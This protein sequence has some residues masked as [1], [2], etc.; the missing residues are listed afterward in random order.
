MLKSKGQ[1]AIWVILGVV[2]IASFIIFFA[3]DRLPEIIKPSEKAGVFDLQSL[4]DQCTSKTVL[5]A[6]DIMLP[7]GGF[8]QPKNTIKY[9]GKNIEYLCYTSEYYE[10]CTQQ[11]P[12]PLKEMKDEIKNYILQPINRCFSEI[13][14]EVQRRGGRINYKSN[15]DVFVD[16]GPNTINIKIKRDATIEQLGE[17]RKFDEF[18]VDVKSPAYNLAE[19]ANEI[20]K[21][22]GNP[23]RCY[24]EPVGYSLLYNRFNITV[25]NQFQD[26]TKVYTIQD[27]DSKEFMR[28]ATRSCVSKAGL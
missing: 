3:I 16:W 11:H 24:F 17:K 7:Q 27:K 15:Y 28:V 23:K 6:V 19:V 21:Q 9:Y 14:T 2:L 18:N 22:E 12:V 1:I 20:A 8:L 4:L 26:G 5:E 13:D 25:Y 10:P